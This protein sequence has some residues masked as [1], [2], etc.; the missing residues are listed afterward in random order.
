MLKRSPLPSPWV[1]ALALVVASASNTGALAGYDSFRRI[2]LAGQP[3]DIFATA[4]V[5]QD[6]SL[7]VPYRVMIRPDGSSWPP[8]YGTAGIAA[9]TVSRGLTV[10]GDSGPPTYS[11]PPNTAVYIGSAIGTPGV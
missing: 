7:R 10:H 2:E 6:I 3:A 9:G 4:G 1:A 8:Y 5:A 11:S